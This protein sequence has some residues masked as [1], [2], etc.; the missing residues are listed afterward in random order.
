MA[1]RLT[2][3]GRLIDIAILLCGALSRYVNHLDE[4]DFGKK[5]TITVL[6]QL[7]TNV[8]WSRYFGLSR[9]NLTIVFLF[10]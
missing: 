7:R 5:E 9:D 6:R 1:E 4:E 2:S 3:C 8:S 10:F